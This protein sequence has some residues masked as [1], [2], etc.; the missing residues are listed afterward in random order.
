MINH[1]KNILAGY[2]LE[3]RK[4]LGPNFLFETNV[5]A[6]IV[7]AADLQPGDEVLEIG[8]GLGSLTSLLAKK[9]GYVVA[10]EL[11][12]RLLPALRGEMAGLDNVEIVEGDILEQ[13]PAAFF[14]GP[15]KVVANVP[16][17][18]TGAIL[19]H[20]LGGTHKPSSMVLTVQ[21]EVA[22]R[23]TAEPPDMSLLAI[24]VL[25]YGDVERVATIK[26]GA[27]WPRPDVDSAVIRIE[28]RPNAALEGDQEEAF[29]KIVRTGFSQK[30]KQLQKNLRQ[31]GVGRTAVATALEKAGIDGTRRAETMTIDEW[32]A[33]VKAF[34][35]QEL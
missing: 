3:P 25:Y 28:I 20:L 2:G 35:A 5:L 7:D 18:I 34:R 22:D 15:Y 12:G 30:R 19:R 16:Y 9:A 33:L 24:S 31:L 10:V 14:T 29:F 32:L 1:P 17:Y 11:D 8:P 6:R 23:L 26:A 27:F 21:K 4:S 13:D